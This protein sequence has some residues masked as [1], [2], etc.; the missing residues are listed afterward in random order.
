MN[1]RSLSIATQPRIWTFVK[2]KVLGHR[3]L[4]RVVRRVDF[5]SFSTFR[6]KG[7]QEIGGILC[8][9]NLLQFTNKMTIGTSHIARKFLA[10]TD[11]GIPWMNAAEALPMQLR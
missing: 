4:N 10:L 3:Q 11:R 2:L 7:I 8:I 6:L 9:M 1:D 5:A